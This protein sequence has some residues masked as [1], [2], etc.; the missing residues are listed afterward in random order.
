MAAGRRRSPCAAVRVLKIAAALLSLAVLLAGCAGRSDGG[1]PAPRDEWVAVP[2]GIGN[3][4]NLLVLRPPAGPVRGVVVAFPWGIGDAPLLAGL[5]DTYWDEA[6]AAAGYAVVG[7]ESYE[8]EFGSRA[9]TLMPAILGWVDRAFGAAADHLI[10]T[11]AS[12]GG[13]DVF[14]AALVI[15]ER[16]TGILAMPGRLGE[17]ARPEVLAGV[18]VRLLVGEHDARWVE[19]ARSTAGHLEAAGAAVQLEI[20]PGQGHVLALPQQDLVDW[21][22]GLR[23]VPSPGAR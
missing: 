15:P 12:R 19:S 9:R 4:M 21:I 1:A 20:V 16:V 11:G 10:L 13:M 6:A 17:D 5:L 23:G 18:P 8:Q 14:H 7:V 2:A 22:E 3:W